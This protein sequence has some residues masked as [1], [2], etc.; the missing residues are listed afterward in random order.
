M[1]SNRLPASLATNRLTDAI[2]R[3]RSSSRPLIDLT[4]SNPTRAGFNYPA[5][6][7]ST[8]ADPRGALYLPAPFGLLT[9]RRAVAAD[10]AR[11]G[12]TVPSDQIVLTASSSEAYS[13]L[14]K[15]LADAGDEILVPRPELSVVRLPHTTRSGGIAAVQLEYHGR[16]M[17][18][19]ASIERA[20]TP[21]TR[22]VLIVSP[23]N[24]T[25]SFVKRDEL[26]RL[27]AL[28]AEHDVAI[29]ADEVF[30]DYE[31]EAGSAMQAGRAPTCRDALTFALGGLSKSVGLPQLK[32]GW[33]AVTGP[34]ARV[35]AALQRLE[36]ICDTYLSVSTPVQA[37]AAELLQSGASVRAQIANRVRENYHELKTQ[38]AAVPSCVALT[39]E[40]GWYGVLQ[41]PSFESEEDLVLRLLDAGVLV[42]PGFFFDFPSES[43]VVLSLLSPSDAFR[44]GAARILRHFA[45]TASVDRHV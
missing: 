11:Q 20:L 2:R 39:S 16:W 21:R 17:L 23:N 1:F 7:L 37:A 12:I 34:A 6:L 41:V 44:D 29:I 30:A 9:A 3:F 43:F 33:I 32:L 5:D 38:T 10:Y 13:L 27:A 28:C 40:G 31:L 15:T 24:P 4:E 8:L 36:H 42:H 25:G 35:D 14:F 45:C 19:V 18:D 22:A 26:E